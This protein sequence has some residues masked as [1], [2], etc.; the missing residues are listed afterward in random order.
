MS[1][2]VDLRRDGDVAWLSF[3][4]GTAM[5]VITTRL[6]ELLHIAIDEV[7]AA[8]P[9]VLMIVGRKESFSAGADLSA[10]RAMDEANYAAFIKSEYEL[11]R[12]IDGLPFLTVA[13]VAGACIGNAAELT[14]ACDFRIAAEG[15]R[16][17]L[18]ETKVG[19]P[20]PMQRLARF[21]GIGKAKELVYYGKVLKAKDAHDIG[22]LSSVVLDEHLM[23]EAEALAWRLAKFAPIATMRTKAAINRVY[24]IDEDFDEEELASALHCF[25]SQDFTE[26]ADAVLERRAPEFAGR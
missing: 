9:R 17:G 7:E 26:G 25:Q 16:W 8:P 20:A 23:S 12:R 3:R 21:V 2:Q 18:P 22:L 15:C 10:L 11:F 13:V 6:L 19:F 4:S 14:L 1:E 24:R 5:N